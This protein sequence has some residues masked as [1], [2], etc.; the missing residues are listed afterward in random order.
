M[1]HCTMSMFTFELQVVVASS[2]FNS[3]HSKGANIL[4]KRWRFIQGYF[5]EDT[6][7]D[8]MDFHSDSSKYL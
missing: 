7:K 1:R 5:E 3:F 6:M 4:G 8:A 2:I